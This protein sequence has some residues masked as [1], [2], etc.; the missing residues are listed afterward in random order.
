M[1]SVFRVSWERKDG[2]AGQDGRGEIGA[3]ERE[4]ASGAQHPPEVRGGGVSLLTEGW[5]SN[6]QRKGEMERS[7]LVTQRVA[8]ILLRV[9]R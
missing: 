4:G 2:G 3:H 8:N 7:N 9:V 1:G 6:Q 5:R